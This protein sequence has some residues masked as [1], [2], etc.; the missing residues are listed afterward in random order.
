MEAALY[1]SMVFR[2]VANVVVFIL[3]VT[4]GYRTS[5]AQSER[6]NNA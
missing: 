5:L 2:R 6:S 1:L 3:V 4:T